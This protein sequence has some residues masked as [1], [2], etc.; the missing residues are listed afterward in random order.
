MTGA[1]DAMVVDMQCIY[2][3]VQQIAECFHTKVITTEEIMKIPASQYLAFNTETAL[4][5]AKNWSVLL[6][7]LIKTAIPRKFP[8][9]T[10]VIN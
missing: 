9:L 8:F 3:A 5:D 10:N 4:D 6:L 1:L 7:K 2:P